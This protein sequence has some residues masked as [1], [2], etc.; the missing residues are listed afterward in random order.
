MVGNVANHGYLLGII[1]KEL[2]AGRSCEITG[3]V[4]TT[5]DNINK[6]HKERDRLV[7]KFGEVV[8]RGSK[9]L[10]ATRD[11]PMWA[12]EKIHETIWECDE[13]IRW[14]VPEEAR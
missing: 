11:P 1:Y 6:L 7:G 14:D 9:T 10:I 4:V 12:R 8:N 13:M 2:S 5:I 3:S